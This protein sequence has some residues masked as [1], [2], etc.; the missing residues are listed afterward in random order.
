[1]LTAS[2]DGIWKPIRIG[3]FYEDLKDPSRYCT[4]VGQ[5]RPN[6]EGKYVT[7]K[8]EDILTQEKIDILINKMIPQAV[9]LH[10]DRLMV[11]PLKGIPPHPPMTGS[12][13][14]SFT[15]PQSHYTDGVQTVDYVLYVAAGPMGNDDIDSG[16]AAWAVACL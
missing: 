16:T 13:C 6:F 3:V 9:Q 8:D 14:G 12:S 15:V 10:A 5:V 11:H 2:G 1:M 4:E 7:C